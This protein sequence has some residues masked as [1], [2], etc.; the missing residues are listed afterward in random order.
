[1]VM[2]FG[3]KKNTGLPEKHCAISCQEKMAFSIPRQVALGLPSSPPPPPPPPESVRG[4]RMYADV[5]TKISRNDR[6][7]DR[8]LLQIGIGKANC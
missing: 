5:R 7:P 1:M 8:A 6:L 3:T 4:G 2:R